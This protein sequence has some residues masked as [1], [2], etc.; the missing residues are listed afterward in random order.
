[1]LTEGDRMS[2]PEVGANVAEVDACRRWSNEFTKGGHHCWALFLN[3][4]HQ[5]QSNTIVN[6]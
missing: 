1:M 4:I 2:S 5:E 6:D 3:A